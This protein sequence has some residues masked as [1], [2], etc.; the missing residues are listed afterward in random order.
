MSIDNDIVREIELKYGGDFFIK[1][2]DLLISLI[3]GTEVWRDI[4][5]YEGQYQISCFGNVK[6][7]I[8]KGNREEKILSKE[9]AR[10][11]YLKAGLWKNN[12]GN[13]LLIH[14][15]VGK[16]YLPNPEN[17]KYINH[18]NGK[19]DNRWFMIELATQ[20]EN[21]QHCYD[22]NNSNLKEWHLANG[23]HQRY[24]N[25]ILQ[26]DCNGSIIK[27]WPSIREASRSLKLRS[28]DINYA[29]DKS[30]VYKDSILE[31]II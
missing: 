25:P 5:N 20:S 2:T 17:K 7:L 27:E 22:L 19:I 3:E 14:R 13:N 6:S 1:N 15:I 12:E 28:H 9:L 10:T 4:D 31:K 30:K 21:M 18:L 16:T 11:G 23:S 8:R 24:S 26:R 29:A